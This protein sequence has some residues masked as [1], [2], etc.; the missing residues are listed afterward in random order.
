MEITLPNSWRPRSY[1]RPLWDYLERGGRR[2]FVVAHRRWGK[3][4]VCLHWAAVSSMQRVGN[5]WHMLPQASQARKAVWEAVNPHTGKRRI[6]EAF[7][8][9]LRA[10]TREN[11]MAI[12]FRN[13]STWQLVGSDNYNSLVGSP[14]VGIVFSE[15]ALADPAAW[16]YLRPIL[17]ENDGWAVFIT[18][19]RGRNHAATFY[20]AALRDSSWFAQLSPATETGVFTPDQLATERAELEREFGPDEGE[21][22]FRQEYLCSF[23]AGVVGAY[24]GHAMEAA[25]RDGRIAGVPWLPHLPVH[26]GWDLGRRD[27]TAIWY[28]QLVGHEVHFI[29]YTEN[30][31]VDI[32]WYA[33][34]LDRKPYK[35]GTH[36]LPHDAESEHLVA[37]KTIAGSL[38]VLGHRKQ[39]IVPRTPDINQAINAARMVLPRC[40]FDKAK[41]ERG[42]AA[43]Q[44]Y[45]RGWDEKRRSFSDRPLHDWASNGADGFRAAALAVAD[46]LKNAGAPKKIV[47]PQMG[48][49]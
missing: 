25:E 6:D 10:T 46:G 37:D 24:Y 2:A 41:C 30:S 39:V 45:R 36:C 7:P 48:I 5:V 9:P 32:T 33:K 34:E 8:V 19:P 40:R 13:G 11:E 1:Q 20:E 28:F 35:Y 18:T 12:R 42:I 38:A 44:N 29:D 14:P 49:V 23:A 43:L 21:Q 27:T 31:G 3:D 4:D 26:T 47:Y 22:R 16:A 15:F 17:A